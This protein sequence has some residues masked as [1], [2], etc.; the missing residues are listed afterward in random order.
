[1]KSERSSKGFSVLPEFSSLLEQYGNELYAYLWRLLQDRHDA[2][3]SLQ[4]T[5]LRAFRAYDRTS[6]DWNYRA[7]LYKIATNVARTRI[8][9]KQRQDRQHRLNPD[10]HQVGPLEA[11]LQKEQLERV[12]IELARLSFRQRTAIIMRKYS[13]LSYSAIA[14]ALECSPESA[15]ANVYQGLKRLRERMGSVKDVQD[16]DH[17]Q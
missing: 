9:N 5:Y 11:L 7:W 1:M 14:E 15:R 2:E 6:P 17:E 10:H 13:E 8:K 4:E 16:D 3:D 12:L